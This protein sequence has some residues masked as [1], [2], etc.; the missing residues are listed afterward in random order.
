MIGS[1]RDL[2]FQLLV[3]WLL[4]FKPFTMLEL[5]IEILRVRAFS[6]PR[7]GT[8]TDRNSGKCFDP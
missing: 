8:T 5:F 4:D 7:V 1:T 2:L 6:H 3:N